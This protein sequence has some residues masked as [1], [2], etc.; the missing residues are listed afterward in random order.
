MRIPFEQNLRILGAEAFAHRRFVLVTF[1]ATVVLLLGLGIFWP[2]SYIS[3]ATIIVDDHV[4]MA[5]LLKNQQPRP[6]GVMDRAKIAQKL[7]R[8]RTIVGQVMADTGWLQSDPSLKNQQRI[9][10]RIAKRITVTDVDKNVIRIAYKDHNPDRAYRTTQDLVR[11]FLAQTST[12]RQRESK[13]AY[14]FIN[15]QVQHYRA[16]VATESASLNKLRANVLDAS[17]AGQ[18]AASRRLMHLQSVRDQARL[19][20]SE[21]QS[22]AA[23][24]RAQ[25]GQ[26]NNTD[27]R[28]GVVDGLNKQ[29]AT[30]EARLGSL[31]LSYQP[32]YPGIVVLKSQISGLKARIVKAQNAAGYPG[33]G[34]FSDRAAADR[35]YGQLQRDLAATTSQ[36]AVLKARVQETHTLL[37]ADGQGGSATDSN[38]HVRQIMRNYSI[39][40]ATLGGL[41]RRRE[42][43][44]LAMSMSKAQNDVSFRVQD[45]PFLPLNPVGPTFAMFAIAGLIAGLILPF[46]LLYV[47]AQMDER[48]RFAAVI[49]DK[50]NLPLVAVVPHLATPAEATGARRSAQ[51]LGVV[52]TSVVL[53]VVS[54][55]LSGS[56][57]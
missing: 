44:R 51:W 5:P 30:D 10:A 6:S 3:A 11:L 26:Q 39:D 21:S 46:M 40:T 47:K 37:A 31:E 29:L 34:S 35:Y 18:S 49:S 28:L 41:L 20:L 54:I 8:S 55:V 17:T 14:Q 7:V 38:A 22:R 25:L 52:V 12:M 24:L 50:L 4:L 16:R 45:A 23:A 27:S 57:T 43:A 1:L 53:I 32:H 42:D 19:E 33:Q 15:G 56:I 48:V 2:R 13:V 9:M 36:I